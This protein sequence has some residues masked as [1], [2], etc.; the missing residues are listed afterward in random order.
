MERRTFLALLPGSLLAAPQAAEAQQARKVYRIGCLWAVPRETAIPYI[1][2]LDAGLN[3][4]GHIEGVNVALEHRFADPPEGCTEICR[5]T[6]SFK[7][8]RLAGY[9]EFRDRRRKTRDNDDP[10]RDA[11]RSRSRRGRVN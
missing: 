11:L 8:G 10:D 6:R 5:G 4:L 1:K 9:D 2:E 7:G 3:D